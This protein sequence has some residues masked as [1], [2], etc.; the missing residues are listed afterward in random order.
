M[1]I[2]PFGAATAERLRGRLHELQEAFV[3]EP[4]T[5]VTRAVA[6]MDRLLADTGHPDDPRDL[7]TFLRF[8]GED[9]L[10]DHNR[11]R[12]TVGSLGDGKA[13]TEALRAAFVSARNVCEAIAGDGARTRSHNRS[14]PL[15]PRTTLT[16]TRR[17]S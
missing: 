17:A 13:S 11:A 6:E 9:V 12:A 1:E 14:L 5:A 15:A 2:L 7:R 4:Q 3:D 16:T 8:R 10:R